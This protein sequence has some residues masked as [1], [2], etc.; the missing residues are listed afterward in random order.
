MLFSSALKWSVEEVRY[1]RGAWLRVY[2]TPV[3]AWNENFFRLCVSGNGRFIHADKCT[4]DKTRL[5]F[6]RILVSTSDLEILNKTTKCVINGRT[7]TIKLV[8][9][10]GCQFGED[11]FMTGADSLPEASCFPD[12]D[13]GLEEVQGEWELDDLVNDLH[14]EWSQHESKKDV[15]LNSQHLTPKNNIEE[16]CNPEF[17]EVQLSPVLQ[18]VAIPKTDVFQCASIHN[19][20]QAARTSA[21]FTKGPWSLDWLSQQKPISEGGVVFSSTCDDHKSMQAEHVNDKSVSS[22]G[23]VRSKKKQVNAVHNLVGFMKKIA[24]MPAKDRN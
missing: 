4:V 18:P 5:D 11:A 21:A 6:A 16:G 2:G 24:R 8:E 10:W 23:T 3:H 17:F 13:V 19:V 14:K 9:E 20:N 22:P 7:Y 12:D 1:E 15:S